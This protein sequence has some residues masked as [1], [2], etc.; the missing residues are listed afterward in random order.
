MRMEQQVTLTATISLGESQATKEF[1]VTLLPKDD[2]IEQI[3]V[4]NVL[5][6]EPTFILSGGDSETLVAT[7]SPSILNK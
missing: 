2:S 7:I 4:K 5:L 1:M 6:N 3:A